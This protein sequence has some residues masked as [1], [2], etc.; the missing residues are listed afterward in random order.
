MRHSLHIL[1]VSPLKYGGLFSKE[2]FLKSGK[3]SMGGLSH[4]VG[5]MLKS[6]DHAKVGEEGGG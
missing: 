2:S 1:S 4:G 5:G 6:S 3:T